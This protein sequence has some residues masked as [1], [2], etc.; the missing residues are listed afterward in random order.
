MFASYKVIAVDDDQGYLNQITGGLKT[1]GIPCMPILFPDEAAEIPASLVQHTRLVFTD[2]HLVNNGKTENKTNY[3]AIGTLLERIVPDGGS[4]VVLVLWTRFPD[5]VE[6]LRTHLIERYNPEKL[7]IAILPLAKVLFD[8]DKHVD[9]PGAISELLQS[10]PA[11]RALI[12]WERDVAEAADHCARRIYNLARAEGG[13]I[14]DSLE[15]LLSQLAVAATG[16]KIARADPGGS[17]H[18]ALLPLLADQVSSL[19][20]SEDGR[21]LWEAALPSAVSGRAAKKKPNS[22]RA[23]AINSSMHIADRDAGVSGLTRGAVISVDD[24]LIAEFFEKSSEEL[25]SHFCVPEQKAPVWRAIQI[26]ATCDYAQQKS[27]TIP[28]VLAVEAP[29]SA[30]FTPTGMRPASIWM[31]PVLLSPEQTEMHLV[32]NVKYVFSLPPGK[33]KQRI[34]KYRLRE[35][36][37]NEVGFSKAQHSIRPGSVTLGEKP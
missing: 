23:A 31:S 13:D 34:A 3:D 7:P 29:T 28:F 18:D 15:L 11:I 33:A 21:K 14:Q 27:P 24:A 30:Q 19:T 32:A 4:P 9:L 10:L 5:E 12:H 6:K 35:A 36:M 26:E 22:A 25:V 2:L 17:I 8:G 1:V 20:G 16:M 37:T